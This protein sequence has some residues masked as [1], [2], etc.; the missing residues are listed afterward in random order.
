[1]SLQLAVG[2]EHEDEAE[3]KEVVDE[4]ASGTRTLR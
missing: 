4:V 3:R 1:M 2:D